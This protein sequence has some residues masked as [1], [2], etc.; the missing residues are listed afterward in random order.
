MS[1]STSLVGNLANAYSQFE[2]IL[3]KLQPVALLAARLYIA[4]VFFA[5]GLTKINDWETTL[6]L[7]ELEYT[8]PL[9]SPVAAAYLGTLGELLL[10][11]LLTLGLFGRV[12]ALGLSVVNIVA[13][14]SL[15]E[16]A[17]AAFTLHL[18]W[19]AL[20]ATIVLW[21]SGKVSI[22]HLILSKYAH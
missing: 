20:L 16:I 10:P 12:G 14:M 15:Q 8:V 13:V 17:P 19:G 21:G 5:A 9:L 4:W 7:F 2:L 6:L 11:V 1:S 22:D 18:L 3:N